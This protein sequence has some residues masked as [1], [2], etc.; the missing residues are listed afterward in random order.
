LDL[1]GSIQGAGGIGGL[2]A[3]TDQNGSTFYHADRTGD[4]TALMDGGENIAARYLYG[5]FGKTLGQWGSNA[6]A[7]M[8]RF[9]SMPYYSNPGIYG[10]WGRFGD[11]NLQRWLNQDPLGEKAGINLYR[12]DGNNPINY[13]DPLGLYDYSAAETQEQFLR[14]AFSSAT[15]G[16]IQGIVNIYNNSK[17]GSQIYDFSYNN[18]ANDTFCANGKRLSAAQFANYIAGY[19][20]KA[21]DQYVTS[22]FP[23]LAAVYTYGLE[24]HLFGNTLAVNDPF[25]RTGFQYIHMGAVSVPT[26]PEPQTFAYQES[27]AYQYGF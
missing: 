24:D 13:V 26:P 27:P 7:N 16:P 12:F 22:P 21:Y 2:L 10:Y 8:M 11:P 1:S 25:D 20:G 15:A 18:H 17:N 9:S 14:P 5:P 23:A 19:Q 3:R 4:I 6:P